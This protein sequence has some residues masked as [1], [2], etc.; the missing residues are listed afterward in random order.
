MLSQVQFINKLL[1][2]KDYSL[3]S[4]NNLTVNYFF[5]YKDEFN[6][7]KNHYDAYKV[8]PD[9]ATFANVFPDFDFV[10]VSEPESFLLEQLYED[11]NQSYLTVS[12]NQM[13]KLLESG[14]TEEA[15]QYYVKSVDDLRKGAAIKCTDL[16]HNTERYDHYVDRTTNWDKYYIS[17]GFAA[18]DKLIGGID[19]ENEN[20]VIAARTGIGKTFT[21]L[22]LA[23]EASKQG[24]TVGIF[25]GEM[26]ADKVGYRID[27]LL[28]N[29]SN[30]DITRGRTEVSYE[31][32]DYIQKL[33][34]L[35]L[36]P[37]KV[38]TPNDISGKPTVAALQAFVEQEKIDILFV[39]QYSLLED[40]SYAKAGHERVA[41]IS[42]AIKKLQVA[43]GIPIISVSQMNR[44]KNEDGTQDT[45][46]I[47]LSDRIGQDATVILMLDKQDDDKLIINIVKSRDGGG[48]HKLTYVCN[49]NYG[50]FTYL[51]S[52]NDH[53]STQEDIDELRNSFMPIE[54]FSDGAVF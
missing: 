1:Q 28:G 10:E 53:V 48:G 8:V 6:F 25:E 50:K 17:T 33:P 52:E 51:P 4:A 5:N 19:R 45:T 20:M 43:K 2:T 26:T 7:I 29:I 24:L 14:K 13:K 30:S 36:G 35:N 18:L 46:Q 22:K 38:I 34:T 40:D 54:D 41:N 31:Y 42:K 12:F 3:I 15:I 49:W 27:T 23:T 44:T 32:K 37:I 21:M 39:D 9:Q 11:Y 16:T 47:G